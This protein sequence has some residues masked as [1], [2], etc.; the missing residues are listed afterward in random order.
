MCVTVQAALWLVLL[1]YLPG[2]ALPWPAALPPPAGTS[3]WPLAR[4]ALAAAGLALAYGLA[5]LGQAALYVVAVAKAG[6]LV[7]ALEARLE[8]AEGH[9][10]AEAAEAAQ[11]EP[12]GEAAHAG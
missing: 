9:P 3:A 4:H 8:P 7:A 11:A 1:A 2:A 6:R 10:A 12:N 5:G